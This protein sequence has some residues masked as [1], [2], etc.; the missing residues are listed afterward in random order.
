MHM[1]S[2]MFDSPKH[3]FYKSTEKLY[4]DVIRE[5]DYYEFAAEKMKEKSIVLSAEAFHQI[6]SMVDGVTWFVQSVLN[7]LYRF[8]PGVI[9]DVELR[10]AVGQIISTEEENYKRIFH[11]LTQNQTQ[12]LKAIA[13]E[14][15][16]KEPLSG[17]FLRTHHL[18]SSSSVQRA[19]QFLTEK[20]YVYQTGDGFIVYD[21]FFSMW[22]RN[23]D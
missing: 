19:L 17:L 10:Q 9:T 21:R 1:M 18:K 12:L 4:L 2:E 5:A 16:V 8:E 14:G 7:R 11:L 13:M 20:E 23:K 22:L 15:L 6:Y 3:P